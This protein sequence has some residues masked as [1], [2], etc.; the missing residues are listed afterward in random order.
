MSIEQ[1]LKS[2]EER[3]ITLPEV[4]RGQVLDR[5]QLARELI[6]TQNPLEFFSS[7][8]TPGERYMLLAKRKPPV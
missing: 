6:G 2:V 3:A 8:K 5:L 4:Q 7:W 1:F